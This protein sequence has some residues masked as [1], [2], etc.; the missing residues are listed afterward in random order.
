MTVAELIEELKKCESD[1]E[2]Y[3]MENGDSRIMCADIMS[4]EYDGNFIIW[5]S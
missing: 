2:V 5:I 1:A 3:I 4:V